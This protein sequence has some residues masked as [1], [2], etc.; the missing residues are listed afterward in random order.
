MFSGKQG[1]GNEEPTH[2]KQKGIRSTPLSCF[3]IGLSFRALIVV[4][5]R[6]IALGNYL[7]NAVDG[8]PKGMLHVTS[9]ICSSGVPA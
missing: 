5:V 3:Q 7:L 6:P 1:T 2:R 8:V 9:V 4:V